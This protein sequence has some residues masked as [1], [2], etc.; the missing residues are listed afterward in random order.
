MLLLLGSCAPKN[1]PKTVA[2]FAPLNWSTLAGAPFTLTALTVKGKE[3]PL[4]ATRRPTIQFGDNGAVS[5]MAGVNR[6]STAATVSGKDSLAWTSPVAATKMAGPPEAMA[7]ENAFLQA[8]EAANK[9]ELR[10]GKLK[11]TSTDGVTRL[12]FQR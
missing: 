1:T 11:L 9:V 2:A 4:P 12:E 8:L 5:G 7:L 10:D 3:T 6:Y